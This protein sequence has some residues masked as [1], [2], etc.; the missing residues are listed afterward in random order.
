MRVYAVAACCLLTVGTMVGSATVAAQMMS[1]APAVGSIATPAAALNAQL[2]LIESQM[3]GAVQA[4][5]AEKFGFAPSQAIF[6]PA[7]KTEF[8]TVRTF[9]QQ[10]A[11][12]AQANYFFASLV[13]G[14][15]PDAKIKDLDKLT[16]KDDILAALADSFTA[17]HKAIATLTAANAFEVIKWP[18]PGLATRATV[19]GFGIAH[20]FDHYGQ[21]VEYLRMNGIVPP[22]SAK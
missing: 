2:G 18:E 8:A 9:G 14:Q 5:P 19:A 22:A 6:A 10:V 16:S 7:Q 20:A 1:A 4:M 12:V 21:M 17:E 11:H 15:P 13:T 3:M